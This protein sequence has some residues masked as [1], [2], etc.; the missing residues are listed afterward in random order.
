VA[1]FVAAPYNNGSITYVEYGYALGRGFPVASILNTAGYYRQPTAENVAIAL[2][3]ARINP[4]R[5]QILSDVYRNGDPRAYPMSSYSYMIAPTSVA[6]GFTAAKGDTLGKF[7]LYFLCT[8]QQKAKRLGYSP[9]PPN[10]VQFAFDAVKTI[11]GSPAPPPI[12][13]CANPTIT[14]EFNLGAVPLPAASEKAGAKA[15]SGG[16]SSGS[17]GA[18]AGAAVVDPAAGPTTDVAVEGTDDSVAAA[19]LQSQPISINKGRD[20]V[21]PWLYIGIALVLMLVVFAPPT[22]AMATRKQE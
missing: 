2:T 9:L 16:G 22:I 3:G 4:D 6:G 15:A 18:G 10:L 21:S 11:P 1:N 19:N 7:I 5:T 8:G 17:G 13:Q 14:G 12:S 20:T